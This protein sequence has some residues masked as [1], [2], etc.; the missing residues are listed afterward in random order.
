MAAIAWRKQGRIFVPS[1]EGFFKTHA[2]RPITYRLSDEVLR[3]YFSSRDADDRMLPAY[4]DVDADNPSKVLR[5]A[6]QPLVGLGEPGTFDDCGVTLASVLDD[7]K[8]EAFVYYT[9]W[10]RRRQTVSF[11]LT[12]GLLRWDKRADTFRRMFTGPILAQDRHHPLLLAGPFVLNENGLYRMWY[13]S[14]T[15]W[16]FPGD[17]P[18]PIY[19]VHYAE[20]RNAIDWQPRPGPVIPYKYDGEVVS[21]PWVIKAKGKYHMW[22]STRGHDSKEAKR[23]RAGYAESADGIAWQRMDE[24]AGLQPSAE[25]WDSEMACYPAIASHGDKLYMF[26]S[27]NGV[28]RGGLGYAVADNVFR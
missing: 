8:D 20:S 3:V 12:L 5:A 27:G 22:Y 24:L 28:G 13:C 1:G 2:T 19:T 11:E 7:G 21:A 18:E 9:G 14:G 26:Y 10:K 17:V 25:G 6:E 23:Y 16:K 15:A 4:I